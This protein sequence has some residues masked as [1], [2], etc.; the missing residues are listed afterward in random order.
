VIAVR[1]VSGDRLI[2]LIEIV[3]A[4]NKTDP[5]EIGALVE[6]TVV[7]LSKGIHVL[8]IDLH[9]PGTYDPEGLHNLIWREIGQEPVPLPPDR[10]LQAVSYLSAGGVRSFIEP[11]TF[12]EE[13]PDMPLFLAPP[14]HVRVPLERTYRTA[15][16]A[17]PAHLREKL[18]S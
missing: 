5:A 9:P 8:L 12:G 3:S 2:A 14:L 16:A 10:P 6:K 1:H 11:R 17:V 4:G 18:A 7:A 13:L 15:F